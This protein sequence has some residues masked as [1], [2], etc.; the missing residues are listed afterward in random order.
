MSSERCQMNR[1]AYLELLGS[2]GVEDDGAD[3]I[4]A[5]IDRVA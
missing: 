4:R 3:N 5:H 1:A 2:E